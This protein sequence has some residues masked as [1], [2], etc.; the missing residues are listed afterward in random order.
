MWLLAQTTL[1]WLFFLDFQSYSRYLSIV[2]AH[3]RTNFR[4]L[5][6]P[7]QQRRSNTVHQFGECLQKDLQTYHR[8]F[9]IKL[10]IH[11]RFHS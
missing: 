9:T 6:S 10:Q 8:R 7:L 5:R 1:F 4:N 11:R 2:D 3:L